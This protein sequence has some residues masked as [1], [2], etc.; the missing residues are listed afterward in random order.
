MTDL[1]KEIDIYL[2]MLNNLPISVAKELS[3][4]FT[5]ILKILVNQNIDM[6]ADVQTHLDDI[7]I[8]LLSM[9]FD[10]EATKAERDALKKKYEG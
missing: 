5:K 4:Q 1:Q 10:L 9:R 6:S 3:D 7:R 2:K 8:E